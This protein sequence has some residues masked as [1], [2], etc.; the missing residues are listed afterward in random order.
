MEVTRER[1]ASGHA[2]VM[3]SNLELIGTVTVRPPKP[4]SSVPLY[5]APHTWSITQLAVAPNLKGRG[6]GKALHDTAIRF[7][8]Q[9]GGTTM[10]LDT[11]KPARRLISLS[12]AWGYR[13]VG[14]VDWR[15]QTNYESVLMSGQSHRDWDLFRC[16][17]NEDSTLSRRRRSR[18]GCVMASKRHHTP[19]ERTLF[20]LKRPYLTLWDPAD[21]LAAYVV[22]GPPI[23]H[24]DFAA[25]GGCQDCSFARSCPPAYAVISVLHRPVESA[26]NSGRLDYSS[27]TNR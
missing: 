4:E 17:I 10:A 18:C 27:T 22:E 1:L 8:V 6:L 23:R 11:A 21:Q 20:K 9:H 13:I 3:T 19:L 24:A 26:A 14:S 7:A 2:L 16:S 5:R 25:Y 12:E 15:P